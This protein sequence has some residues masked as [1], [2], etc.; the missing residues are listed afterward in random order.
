MKEYR[1]GHPLPMQGMSVFVSGG[2]GALGRAS[3]AALARMGASVTL[4][5]RDAE[6]LRE[7]A[8]KTSVELEA[9]LDSSPVGWACIDL[10]TDEGFTATLNDLVEEKGVPDSLVAAAGSTARIDVSHVRPQ[11]V[12]DA[13]SAK[14]LPNV[15]L[16]LGFG[17]LMRTRGAGQIVVVS[18]VGGVQPMDVHLAGGATNAALELFA[19]GYA[20]VVA[21]EGVRVNVVNPGAVRGPRLSGHYE[22]S[23]TGTGQSADQARAHLLDRIPAGREAEPEEVA[24]VIAFMASP[25]SSY[26]VA[27]TVNVD[28]GQVV[29]P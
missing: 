1:S 7:A 3:A 25:L 14:L 22:A 24:N 27:T 18:G 12:M 11:D 17:P 5:G 4:L 20:R 10:D 13:M 29:G 23:A 15:R 8:D 16:I 21:A 9:D 2:T 28:G 26:M 19:I 6:R